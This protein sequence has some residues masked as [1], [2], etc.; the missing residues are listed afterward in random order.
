ML[1]MREANSSLL[2]PL[3]RRCS[4]V[5]L[6]ASQALLEALCTRSGWRATQFPQFCTTATLSSSLPTTGWPLM[7]TPLLLYIFISS[8]L[9]LSSSVLS[10]SSS[11][12]LSVNSFLVHRITTTFF[13]PNLTLLKKAYYLLIS[14]HNQIQSLKKYV[15]LFHFIVLFLSL[16]P[17]FI[18]YHHPFY[19]RFNV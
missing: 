9:L 5:T 17:S 1:L 10:L 2:R 12:T 16:N 6:K 14:K 4:W 3:R 8:Q 7:V 18:D 19:P 15:L 13:L 11:C